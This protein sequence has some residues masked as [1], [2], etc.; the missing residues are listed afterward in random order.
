MEY[1]YSHRF[2]PNSGCLKH[3]RVNWITSYIR[4]RWLTP[5][6][7]TTTYL[8]WAWTSIRAGS[9]V[10]TFPIPYPDNQAAT[11]VDMTDNEGLYHLDGTGDDTSSN[12]RNLTLFNT[13]TFPAGK[14]GT[15]CIQFNGTNQYAQATVPTGTI[16][17]IACWLQLTATPSQSDVFIG[18]GVT[19]GGVRTAHGEPSVGTTVS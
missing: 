19:F 13:P 10:H 16:G 12:T 4:W 8:L 17:T 11:P 6:D 18:L 5:V 1:L 7:M 9:T 14:V 3:H 2:V 15:N